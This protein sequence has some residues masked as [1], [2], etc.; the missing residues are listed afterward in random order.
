MHADDSLPTTI[1]AT[2]SVASESPVP[3][4]PEP[5]LPSDC[6]G[7]GCARCVNDVYAEALEEWMRRYGSLRA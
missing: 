1:A 7:S 3:P 6:C 4:R 5:P 2:A